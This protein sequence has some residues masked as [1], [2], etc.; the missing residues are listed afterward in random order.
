MYIAIKIFY[1]V[2]VILVLMSQLYILFN[3]LTGL[4]YEFLILKKKNQFLLNTI[5]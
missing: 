3:H 1:I 5:V 4:E 2:F